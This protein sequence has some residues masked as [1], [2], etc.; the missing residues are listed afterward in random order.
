MSLRSTVIFDSQRVRVR[1]M[2]GNLQGAASCQLN[3]LEIEVWLGHDIPPCV[4]ICSFN[5][6]HIQHGITTP[7]WIQ[8]PRRYLDPQGTIDC[9]LALF[10]YQVSQSCDFHEVS[11]EPPVLQDSRPGS[12][13]VPQVPQVPR[14]RNPPGCSEWWRPEGNRILH[15]ESWLVFDLPLWKMMEFV[16]WDYDIL[17]IPNIWKV[18]KKEVP[19]HQPESL[20][21][22]WTLMSGV[23]FF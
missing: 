18:I 4:A 2:W 5:P 6:A 7:I 19:N 12:F 10:F 8:T 23:L 3:Q 9:Q 11:R 21:S 16:S 22:D 14:P 15:F 1:A 13:R 20:R 17:H